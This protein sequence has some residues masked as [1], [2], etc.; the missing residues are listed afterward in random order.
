MLRLAF[1]A[2][3]LFAIAPKVAGPA[4]D[5]GTEVDC[6][7][8][9]RLHVK[10][11]GGSDGA[12][13]CVFA[14]MRHSGLWADE[15]VFAALFEWMFSR[16]GGGYPQKVE[17][18]V[19]LYCRLEKKPPPDYFQVEGDDLDL[20]RKAVAA[21][22]MPAVT[23]YRSPTGRYGG[24]RVLHMVSLVAAGPKW[25]AILDNNFPGTIEWMSREDFARSFTGGSGKGWAVVLL[26]PGP[27]PLPRSLDP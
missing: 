15:P 6:D 9:A 25:W 13:L 27:P 14:S 20:L 21:G 2:L 3:A 18:M 22:L 10:N 24:R 19:A 1:L 16:P 11:R 23:Y 5:D 8:P 12:G 17:R 26:K 4:L 7:L